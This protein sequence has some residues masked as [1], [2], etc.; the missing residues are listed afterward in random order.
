MQQLGCADPDSRPCHAVG[1]AGTDYDFPHTDGCPP[2]CDDREGQIQEP[3]GR[4]A[5][6]RRFSAHRRLAARSTIQR[7]IG[8]PDSDA[9]LKQGNQGQSFAAEYLLGE[10]RTFL[11]AE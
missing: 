5:L 4:E 11:K 2:W 10:T 7:S 3:N 8:F 6:A 9:A 1:R